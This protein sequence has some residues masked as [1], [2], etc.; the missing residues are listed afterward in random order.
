MENKETNAFAVYPDS[1]RYGTSDKNSLVAIFKY[2][3]H[4]TEYAKKMWHQFYVITPIYS[5]LFEKR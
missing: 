2:E 4:A 3:H 1:V 5:E